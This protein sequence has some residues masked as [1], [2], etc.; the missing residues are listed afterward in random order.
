MRT[1]E[2]TECRPRDTVGGRARRREIERAAAEVLAEVGYSAASVGRIAQQAGVSKGVITYHYSSKDDLLRRVALGLFQEC[3]DHLAAQSVSTG[4]PV[5]RLC[6]G[7]RAE[8]E[9]FAP[10][11]VEF[12]AMAEVMANHRDADFARA[13]ADVSA[14]ETAARADLLREGRATGQVRACDAEGFAHLITAAKNDVLDRWAAD[15]SL[16]LASATET[17]VDFVTGAVTPRATP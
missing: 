16:D 4:G 9:F 7:I 8:L 14:A 13:F 3:A 17:L 6:T 1:N 10:R 15:E 5:D 11:R 2:V 12:Q